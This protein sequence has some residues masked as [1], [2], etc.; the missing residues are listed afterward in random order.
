MKSNDFLVYRRCTTYKRND[1]RPDL[2]FSEFGLVFRK[3]YVTETLVTV[4][5][6]DNSTGYD[7]AE[8]LED[9]R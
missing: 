6:I 8:Q 4:I 2:N 7:I 1:I 3:S 9:K 5:F